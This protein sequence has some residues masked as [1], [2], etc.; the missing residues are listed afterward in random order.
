MGLPRRNRANQQSPPAGDDFDTRVHDYLVTN[1]EVLLDV[2]VALQR[3]QAEE[4]QKVAQAALAEKQDKIFQP[5]FD[6]VLGNP[7]GAITVVEFLTIIVA[8]AGARLAI[9]TRSSPTMTMCVSS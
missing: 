6:A 4:Q 9:W 1:P 5:E 8:I 7:D 3:K 2:Q